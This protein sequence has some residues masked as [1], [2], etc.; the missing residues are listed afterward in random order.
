[1][2]EQEKINELVKS[3]KA[4]MK[5]LDDYW[6]REDTKAI[7]ESLPDDDNWFKACADFE[8][9]LELF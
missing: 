2:N 4:L 5:A 1:M 8:E 9:I 6:E 7:E 3:G